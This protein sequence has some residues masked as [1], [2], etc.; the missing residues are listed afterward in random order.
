MNILKIVKINNCF[1]FLCATH[2]PIFFSLFFI[3]LTQVYPLD[4]EELIW[5]ID[6]PKSISSSF[7]EPRPGR[8]HYGVDFRSGGVNGKKVY[9][10]GDGYISR[11]T[12]SPF[13]YGKS[14]YITMDSGIITVY[15]HLSGYTPEIEERLFNERIKKKSY[16]LDL[17][18]QPGEYRVTKGQLV[19][20]SGDSGSGASHLHMEIRNRDNQ[21]LNP[22]EHGINITDTI[23]PVMRK[24]VFIPLDY[25]SSV[26][27]Y[28]TAKW[29]D[30][31]TLRNESP[32]LSGKIGVAVSIWDQINNSTNLLG[33]YTISLSSDSTAVF[34]KQYTRI[35]Y[36]FNGFGGLD[37]LSGNDFGGNGYLSALFRREG[38]NVDFYNGD[39][40]LT[41]RSAN[42]PESH[43]FSI[44][45]ADYAGNTLKYDFSAVF[46][47]YP[48]F[49]SCGY[50]GDDT[51]AITGNHVSG[52]LDRIELWRSN[53]GNS[54]VFDRSV[55]AKNH[56]QSIIDEMS[57][58]KKI[59]YK[60]ILVAEDSTRS[61]PCIFSIAPAQGQQVED[62]TLEITPQ[63]FHDRVFIRI[64]SNSPLSSLPLIN[65]EKNGV[66]IEKVI[67][68]IPE[69]DTSWIASIPITGK[70][71]TIFRIKASAY[72]R[73]LNRVWN[74][75]SVDFTH[76]GTESQDS[77]Y[78]P[79]SLFSVTVNP[80]F[81][82]RPAPVLVDTA[83]VIPS[84]GLIP[85]TG[86]YVINWG[87]LPLKKAPQIRLSM[88]EEPPEG[89]ALFVSNGGNGWRFLSGE[90]EGLTYTG[91]YGSS[92]RIAVLADRQ[93]PYVKPI[94]PNPGGTIQNRRPLLK[95]YVEDKGSGIK[96]SDSISMFIDNIEAYGEYDFEAHTVS[97]TLFNELDPGKHT[98]TVKV[99]D[100][101]G[102]VQTREWSF[103]IR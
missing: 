86:G 59:T 11:I 75:V 36:D 81:L 63:L 34:S 96:G 39:G 93:P 82:Y 55:P 74:L 10:V 49:I 60:A 41:A 97:Y 102:N 43:V 65:M 16:D 38:N 76:M 87:D 70:G 9:A 95:A 5:P 69:T 44:N 24:I 67:S 21:P 28:P 14:L 101:T 1:N 88:K 51:I 79:D 27:G 7:G 72:D 66:L 8:F 29:Y 84:N 6:S 32:M 53:E 20:Y 99:T 78:S 22:F 98:V 68:T 58:E 77:V 50:T 103:T 18:P 64:R 48:V 54:W 89:S 19:A 2:R 83:K 17:W 73:N 56:E 100:R 57:K 47:T 35:P 37:Y 94:S 46:G 85:V 23:T 80:G 62:S 42:L 12:T 91:S 71:H 3:L 40:V 26:D 25:A 31:N 92:G 4:A 52:E 33:V 15:G 30:L 90:R 61:I 13:G 45:A